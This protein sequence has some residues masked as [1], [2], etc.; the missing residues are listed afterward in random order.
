MCPAPLWRTRCGASASHRARER[1]QPERLTSAKEACRAP[2]PASCACYRLSATVGGTLDRA[3][4]RC[5]RPAS[6]NAIVAIVADG[7]VA[8]KTSDT[9]IKYKIESPL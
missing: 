3:R 4:S 5:K 7:Q 9:S 6:A 2:E 8:Q 1:R